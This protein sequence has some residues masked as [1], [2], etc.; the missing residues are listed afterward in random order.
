LSD[1]LRKIVVA[2]SPEVNRLN[3]SESK[4]I[5]DLSGAH[6]VIGIHAASLHRLS[7]AQGCDTKRLCIRL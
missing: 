5:C 3:L 1:W 2:P 7:L 6:E 4:T